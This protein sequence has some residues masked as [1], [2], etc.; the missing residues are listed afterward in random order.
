MAPARDRRTGFSRRRQYGAFIGYVLAVA[1]A[2]VGLVL[3][4]VST[5]DPP[6]FAALRM[7]LASITA[8]V[9]TTLNTGVRAVATIPETVGTYFRVHGENADLRAEVARTRKMLTQ[10]RT[11]AYDNRRLRRLLRLRDRTTDTVVVARLVSSTASSGRR[12]AL[13]NAGVLQGVRSGMPVLGPDGLIGRVIEI[14]PIAARVL[15]L[16]DPESVVPVRRMS[17]GLPGIA[18][19]RGDG[20]IDIRSVERTNVRFAK[21]DA[22]V[23]SGAGGLYA[24]GILVAKVERTGIDQTAAIPFAAPATLDFALVQR[25]FMPLP[26]APAAPIPPPPAAAP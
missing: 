14:G 7:T 9:S 15:L 24:P 1:G 16:T 21:G 22:F 19:G 4:A 6:A 13:L 10:A 23:T 18:S 17:D 25:P 20:R 5:F 3:L 12:F 26:R 8:P 11:I 2:A